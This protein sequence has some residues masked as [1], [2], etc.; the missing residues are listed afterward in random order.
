MPDNA[1]TVSFATTL[2]AFGNNTGI[3][4]PTD[5]LDR[6]G[7]GKRPPVDV[8]INGYRYRSTIGAMNGQALISV[9]AA[10]RKEASL[11]AGDAIKVT[12]VLN[13]TVRAVDIPEDFAAALRDNQGTEGFFADLSNSLQRYHID[14]IDGAKTDETRQRRIEK[15]VG[16]FLAGKKR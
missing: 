14:Q 12:L 16:L 11:A 3:V 1:P 10:I 6:L 13:N 15:A 8:D 7:A 5:V 4:V 9:S 2:T